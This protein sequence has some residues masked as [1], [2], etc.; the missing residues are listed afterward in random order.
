M[1]GFNAVGIEAI[2]AY[3]GAASV[4]V[5]TL[6]ERRGLNI[7]RF[8]NLMMKEKSVG[9]PCEDPVTNAVNAAKPIIDRL[10]D[11]E[12]GRIEWVVTGSESG[13]DFGKSLASYVHDLLDLPKNC[14]VFETKQACYAGTAALQTVIGALASSMSPGAKALVIATDIDEFAIT[15]P[16]KAEVEGVDNYAEPSSGTGAVAVLLSNRPRLFAFDVGA[17]GLHSF[18]VMDTFRPTAG[19][20]FGD[21]DLSLLSY[22]DCAVGAYGDYQ[23]RVAEAHYGTTFD[24]V[25]FHTPFGGMVK[26]THRKLMRKYVKAKPAEIEADFQRR[27]APSLKFCERV[28]NVY[29]ATTFLALCGVIDQARA[30]QRHRVGLFSY[31]SGCSSEFYSGVLAAAAGAVLRELAMEGALN[32]RYPLTFDEY[33]ALM[34]ASRGTAFGTRESRLDIASFAPIYERFF[35]GRGLLMLEE[36][37][38]YHRRYRWS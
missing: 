18:E 12:K 11:V 17:Y 20:T 25:G 32:R 21:P 8:D 27:G 34:G 35:A 33:Q 28:G 22:M 30:G 26:G 4:D 9:V 3:M 37:K 31:G 38:G 6:F 36:I 5:R 13:L 24:Y 23:A 2:H 7:E 10:S 29:S 15:P 16:E 19:E 1:S 14:R